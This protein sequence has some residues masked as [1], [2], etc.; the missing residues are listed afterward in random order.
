MTAERDPDKLSKGNN[1]EIEA[2]WDGV[3]AT[4]RA[5]RLLAQQRDQALWS[6]LEGIARLFDAVTAGRND[7]EITWWRF[8]E[9]KGVRR[10]K[11]RGTPLLFYALIEH[12]SSKHASQE[13]RSRSVIS[14]RAA[15]LQ[16][17]R[18]HEHPN[19]AATDVAQWIARSGGVKAIAE[20]G[21]KPAMTK[22]ERK[23]A[24]AERKAAVHQLVE[25]IPL[26][27]LSWDA[28]AHPALLPYA[29][30]DQRLALVEIV[31]PMDGHT[32]TLKIIGMVDDHAVSPA[33]LSKHAH[34]IVERLP[35]TSRDRRPVQE[36]DP[37]P[38][39]EPDLA[40]LATI[41]V[42]GAALAE[43]SESDSGNED[44]N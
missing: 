29:H 20:I 39:P 40:G 2:L 6:E 30:G 41:E 17:W 15:V 4:F 38:D 24:L 14:R 32:G 1:P 25:S 9:G 5:G 34:Q 21:K 10:G 33:W 11:R 43:E 26:I 31:E 42:I 23:A 27:E 8:L 3:V 16:R 37:F 28:N 22:S 12:L 19:V 7:P 36:D 35:E 44:R 18:D 13:E